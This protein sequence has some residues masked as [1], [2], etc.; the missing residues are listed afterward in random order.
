MGF[1][2]THAIPGLAGD[3]EAGLIG[4]VL[5]R[6]NGARENPLGWEKRVR[7]ME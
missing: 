4:H 6:Q 1:D 5:G 3:D 2:L 7:C